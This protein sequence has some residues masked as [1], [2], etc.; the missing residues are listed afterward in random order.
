MSNIGVSVICAAYNQEQYIRK[1]LDG[2]VMQKTAFPVEFLIHDDASSDRTAAIIREYADRYPDRIIP[3]L[4]TVNQYSIGNNFLFTQLLPAARGKY[5]AFCEGDDYW[6]DPEKLQ[7][8]YEA[9]EAHPECSFCVHQVQGISEDESKLL[10]KFPKASQETGT[11]DSDQLA[12]RILEDQEWVYHTTSYFMRTE[13][14]REAVQ[15]GYGFLANALYPD[16]G[17]MLLGLY[18]GQFFYFDRSMSVYRMQAVGGL[19]NNSISRLER[20]ER[21]RNR[22]LR[23]I[24]SIQDFDERTEHRYSEYVQSFLDYMNCLIAES[25]GNYRYLLRRDMRSTFRK[26]P[27]RLRVRAVICCVIPGFERFYFW[28]R[29]KVKGF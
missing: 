27:K 12:R 24:R 20:V 16:H 26:F 22:C 11:V 15:K 10:R 14:L 29:K 25:D 5:I 17:M 8:Q 9:M 1:M 18:A 21:R 23:G 6:T 2:L 19:T 13:L 4:D 7:L 3:F 28:I